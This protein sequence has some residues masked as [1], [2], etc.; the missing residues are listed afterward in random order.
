MLSMARVFEEKKKMKKLDKPKQMGLIGELTFFK[1][2][3]FIY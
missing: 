2:I 3:I 1:K